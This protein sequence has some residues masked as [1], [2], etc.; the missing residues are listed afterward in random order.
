MSDELI[1]GL[2]VVVTINGDWLK[3][4]Q[5]G[6]GD[7][8]ETFS[9][10]KIKCPSGSH[11]AGFHLSHSYE[12]CNMGEDGKEIIRDACK[13]TDEPYKK[14]PWDDNRETYDGWYERSSMRVD[15]SEAEY[16]EEKYEEKCKNFKSKVLPATTV[17]YLGLWNQFGKFAKCQ[18]GGLNEL[19]LIK[20]G[21]GYRFQWKCCGLFTKKK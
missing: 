2:V 21:S 9:K 17:K 20:S 10:H 13:G 11:I 7:T 1:I 5:G 6:E 4:K 3:W 15:C 16:D 12:C 18:Y 14:C 8:G 19:E